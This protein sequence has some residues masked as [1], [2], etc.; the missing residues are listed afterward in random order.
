MRSYIPHSVAKYLSIIPWLANITNTNSITSCTVICPRL[1]ALVADLSLLTNQSHN[2]ARFVPPTPSRALG[3]VRGLA[4]EGFEIIGANTLQTAT[5]TT[6]AVYKARLEFPPFNSIPS[7]PPPLP[8]KPLSKP[9]PSNSSTCS[10]QPSP[11]SSPRPSQPAPPPS[12]ASVKPAAFPASTPAS[13]TP[14]AAV[15]LSR[16][17]KTPSSCRAMLWGWLGARTLVLGRFPARSLMLITL[18]ELVCYPRL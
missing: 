17:P 4:R 16:G 8:S 7:H 6:L 15:R 5:Q 3:C 14:I 10:S 9:A 2:Q 12:R 1:K 18:A 11:S 13:G